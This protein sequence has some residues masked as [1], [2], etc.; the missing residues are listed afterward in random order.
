MDMVVLDKNLDPIKIIDSYESLIWTERYNA[1][2]DFE[3]YDLMRPEV[4]EYIK[5]DYY[6]QCRTSD[7]T[8]ILEKIQITSDVENGNRII[9]TGR[10]LESILD[11]RI[12]WGQVTLRGNIQEVI[13]WLLTDNIINPLDPNRRIPNFVFKKSEDIR[14][15]SFMIHA[16]YTGDSLYDVICKICD[17]YNIGFKI[18]LNAEKEF[19]FELYMGIDRSYEQSENPYVI[20]SPKFSNIINGNYVQ[21][22][23]SLKTITLIGGEGEGRERKYTVVGGGQGLDRRELFTDARD[24]SSKTEE[25]VLLNEEEYIEQ[26]V[27]RGKE[28][29]SEHIAVTSFE[30]E[31]DTITLFRYGEDFYNGDIV[32]ITNEYGHE[33]TARILEV[34]ISKDKEGYSVYPTFKMI[35]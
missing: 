31:T 3:L 2:G 7:Y 23:V 20:F 13:E 33:A 17:E 15:E 29:L 10:S 18:T 34:V 26:L 16:Q 22:N 9:I 5:Q 28:R 1:Y 21:H 24:I 4:L 6:L 35:G 14:M 12:V 25:G 32:Q 8:M 11:R 27:R 30:G 19:V